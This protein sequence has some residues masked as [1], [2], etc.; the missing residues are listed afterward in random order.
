MAKDKQ[1]EQEIPLSD[2]SPMTDDEKLDK[3]KNDISIDSN[4]SDDQRESADEDMR[5]VSNVNGQWEGFREELFGDRVRL[6]F[7]ITSDTLNR[8]LGEFSLNRVSV[9]YKPD[10]MATTDEDAELLNGIYRADFNQYGGDTAIDNAVR[11]AA[12]TGYGA[13][14]IATV[15]EDDEDVENDNQRIEFRIIPNAYN[16]TYW[17]ISSQ[18]IDKRDARHCTT[19]K[20]YTHS[21]F[22]AKWPD[23]SP[24]S[25]YTPDATL[26][27]DYY[28]KRADR[29]FIATRYEV[30][31]KKTN[32]YIYNNVVTGEVQRYF[33]EDYNLIKDE[34]KKSEV[35]RFSKKRKLIKQYV[36]KTVF[37]GEKILSATRR[38]AG[39]WIPIIPVYAR[40][41]YSEG[42][43]KYSGIVRDYK[44]PQR[45]YNMQISQLAE[46]A[47]SSGQG[48]TPIVT[49]EQVMGPY[50]KD[51][52]DRNNKPFLVLNPAVNPVTGEIISVGPTG[53]LPPSQ[54]DQSTA[55][56]V[57]I[58][59][60]HVQKLSG[61]I[62]QDI[63]DPN[64]SGKA[65]N[66]LIKRANLNTQ[67]IM[68]NISKAVRWGG[69]VYQSI[70]AE[71]YT[72]RRMIRTVGKDGTENSTLLMKVVMDEQTG[73]L[74]EGNN[75]RGKRFRSIADTGP[76][77]ESLR[78]QM[79]DEL[80]SMLTALEKTPQA[81]KYVPIIIG[82]ILENTMGVGLDPLKEMVN[83]DMI[84]MGLK[85]PKTDE[86]KQ[87]L[88]DAQQPKGPDPQQLL[89]ESAAAQQQAEARNL[90][91]KSISNAA[92]AEKK[93]AETQKLLVD[94]QIAQQEAGLDAVDK[95]SMIRERAFKTAQ[96]GL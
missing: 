94:T 10:D 60:S 16:T 57:E 2:L 70:A 78:E 33:E 92:D 68:D 80:K 63:L 86:E 58:V 51:W 23:A 40:R 18:R 36:E 84:L 48:S 3:Y 95:I 89:I 91:S 15:Y 41:T 79:V 19:L 13:F 5:F 52:A 88:A 69:E 83:K 50:A 42:L 74:V 67:S 22:K 75:I 44:D 25:A 71:I 53:Y 35:L 7:D 65:I 21:S 46:N 39:K 38:I 14:K 24:V 4:G 96:Q 37:S 30:V 72:T 17:D 87:L 28:N 9:E 76:S 59:Q 43:E 8:F 12:T 55:S 77:Y 34:L 62:E 90:D 82:M 85:K 47:A 56:L 73:R 66:A 1:D 61:G 54:L 20:E 27:A 6:Q 11:E 32:V 81:A 64:T 26:Y 93:Q 29:I 31:R 45:L 49:P